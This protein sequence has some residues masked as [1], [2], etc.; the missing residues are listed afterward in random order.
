MAL[1]FFDKAR[2]VM[3]KLEQTQGENIRRA[4]LLISEAIRG[5][6][7]LQAYGSGHSYAGAIEVCGRAGGLIPSK[8]IGEPQYGEFEGVEGNAFYVMR[9][10]DI[11]PQDVFILI[12]NSGRNPMTIEMADYIKK[13]GNP[14]IVV[15]A[16]EVSKASTSRHSS[17]KLLYE[18]ADVVLDNQS[19]FGDAALDIGDLMQKCAGRPLSLGVSCFSRPC[20]KQSATWW[21]MVTCRRFTK[22][23]TSMAARNSTMHWKISMPTGY[24]INKRK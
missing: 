6:G 10:V 22:V 19:Q 13:K 11:R 4:A 14:L 5:G 21:R 24:G 3:E 20:T 23:Q 2:E 9:K 1:E 17:G 8:V 12:S 7:I 16:L 18:F 15:T